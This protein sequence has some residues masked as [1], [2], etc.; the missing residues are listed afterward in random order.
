MRNDGRAS[1]LMRQ[2][3]SVQ[4]KATRPIIPMPRH[5]AAHTLTIAWENASFTSISG[6]DCFTQ[7]SAPDGRTRAQDDTTTRN[8]GPNRWGTDESLGRGSV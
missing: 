4:P 5:P 2:P 8:N 1:A 6:K 7:P 3:A